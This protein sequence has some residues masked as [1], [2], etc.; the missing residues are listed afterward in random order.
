MESTLSPKRVELATRLFVD[1]GVRF[2]V[3]DMTT[4]PDGGPY[5]LI[6]MLDVYEH[7]PAAERPTFHRTLGQ[8]LSEAGTVVFT[9]PS[10][11]HQ[12]Y[13][14]SHNPGGLQIVDEIIGLDEVTALAKDIA[15][16]VVLFEM[17][18]IWHTNDYIHAAITRNPT[19]V[20]FE[21]PPTTGQGIEANVS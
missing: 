7:I 4:P 18:T 6:T 2:S 13:L 16:T 10:T 20:P 21:R 1:S 9:C 14:I 17:V 11:I 15:G 8:S 3:S 12:Q 5:D 19:Y